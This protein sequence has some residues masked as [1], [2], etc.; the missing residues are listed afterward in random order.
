MVADSSVTSSVRT[1]TNA[2]SFILNMSVLSCQVCFA[3][4]DGIH[5]R[6][7]HGQLMKTY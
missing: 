2:S 7:H 4:E 5:A 1:F 3:S 6:H